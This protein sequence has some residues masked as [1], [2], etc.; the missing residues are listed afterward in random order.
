VKRSCLALVLVLATLLPLFGCIS[1]KDRT[2]GKVHYT[3]GLSYLREPNYSLALKEFYLAA[4]AN[5]GDPNI[6]LSMGQTY[7]LMRSY[8]DAEKSY[9]KALRLSDAS[10]APICQN[11]LGALY[12]DMKRWDDA[13]FYF[14]LAS[15]NLLFL[16]PDVANAGIGYAH[17]NKGDILTAISFYKKSLEINSSYATAH[18]RL[19]EAYEAFGKTD[20]AL[21][22]YQEV[23]K[24]APNNPVVQFQYGL[25]SAK[26]GKKNQAVQ[27]FRQV[28]RIAPDSE[29]ARLAL[30]HIKLLQ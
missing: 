8:N 1:A 13:I 28:I 12:L 23:V 7:Q 14:T 15:K 29:E 4:E 25:T 6:H 3:L 24:M 19:A 21:K 26:L 11:N 22:E 27:A 9:K 20:L 18:M 16:N 17:F 10:F 30:D 5:P 2:D